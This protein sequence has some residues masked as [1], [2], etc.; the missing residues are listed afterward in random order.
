V[1][2]AFLRPDPLQVAKD[3]ARSAEQF[4]TSRQGEPAVLFSDR[5]IRMG[6]LALAIANLAMVGVMAV[7]PVHCTAMGPQ[8]ARSG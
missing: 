4:A 7:A 8:W 3:A 6:L 1:L 2:A 5:H